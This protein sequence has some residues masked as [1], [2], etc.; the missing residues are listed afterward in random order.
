M[1]ESRFNLETIIPL[2][3]NDVFFPTATGKINPKVGRLPEDLFQ[4]ASN[5]IKKLHPMSA[6]QN[7]KPKP[8]LVE[9]KPARQNKTEN[10]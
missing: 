2:P 9:R 8:I 5:I 3:F 10:H 6:T 1:E 4:A 7:N